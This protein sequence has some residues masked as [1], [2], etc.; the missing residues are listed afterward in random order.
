[1]IWIAQ[2]QYTAEDQ[3]CQKQNLLDV[4]RASK[5]KKMALNL[6]RALKYRVETHSF[7]DTG[8]VR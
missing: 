6:I 7:L 3:I 1:M 2:F 4:F 5:M 8:T